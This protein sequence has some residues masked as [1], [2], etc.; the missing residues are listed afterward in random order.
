[1]VNKHHH[2]IWPYHLEKLATTEFSIY[3]LGH[4]ILLNNT[5]ILA[6]KSRCMDKIIRRDIKIE[7]HPNNTNREKGFSLNTSRKPLIHILKEQKKNLSK[8]KTHISFWPKLLLWANSPPDS[9]FLSDGS[10]K[11][12]YL[13]LTPLGPLYTPSPPSTALTDQSSCALSQFSNYITHQNPTPSHFNPE[14]EGSTFLHN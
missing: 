8:K 13:F 10:E 3:L 6:K 4:C 7:L 11:G 14:D 12:T 9:A 1:M 2:H 5:S